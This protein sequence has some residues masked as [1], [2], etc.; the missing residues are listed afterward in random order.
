[1][2]FLVATYTC[3]ECLDCLLVEPL[4]AVLIFSVTTIHHTIALICGPWK[5]VFFQGF[6]N[7][8]LF[9]ALYL[10]NYKWMMREDMFLADGRLIHV[11]KTRLSSPVKH[12]PLD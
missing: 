10:I 8:L 9:R 7:R 4:L 2:S 11:T 6:N 1:M 5:S 3:L 12:N